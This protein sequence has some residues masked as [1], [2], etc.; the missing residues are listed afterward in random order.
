MGAAVGMPCQYK[1]TFQIVRKIQI[2]G[3]KFVFILFSPMVHGM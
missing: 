3:V 2:D 1:G